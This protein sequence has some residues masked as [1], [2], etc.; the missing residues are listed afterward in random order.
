MESSLPL[1]PR[2]YDDVTVFEQLEPLRDSFLARSLEQ[3]RFTRTQEAEWTARIAKD[4]QK[5]EHAVR[6]FFLS[7]PSTQCGIFSLKTDAA[8]RWL[9]AISLSTKREYCN[10]NLP[11]TDEAFQLF[12]QFFWFIKTAEQSTANELLA[13]RRRQDRKSTRLN[14]SHRP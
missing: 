10:F 1:L 14:S 11:L 9:K 3:Q 7:C 8:I 5:N 4:V 13:D 6:A 2:T 12:V